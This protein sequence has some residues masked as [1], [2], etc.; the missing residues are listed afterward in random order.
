VPD[1][2]ISVEVSPERLPQLLLGQATVGDCYLQ[3]QLSVTA[4]DRAEALRLLDAL[5][6]RRPMLLPRAQWW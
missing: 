2:T 4:P 5:F 1:P 3:D 6:P